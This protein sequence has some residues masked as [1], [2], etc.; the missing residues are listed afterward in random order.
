QIANAIKQ[1]VVNK[2]AIYGDRYESSD[3]IFQNLMNNL[4]NPKALM[5]YAKKAVG[6]GK[7]DSYF[8]GTQPSTWKSLRM[9][10][11]AESNIWMRDN[12]N[13]IWTATATGFEADQ[14][15][16]MKLADSIHMDMQ[17]QRDRAFSGLESINAGIRD[18]LMSAQAKM[19]ELVANQPP[20]GH[21]I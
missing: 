15:Q 1:Y 6:T 17:T 5:E 16:I 2:N 9:F 14:N 3:V 18:D 13:S 19:Q 7:Y 4:K 11:S 20:Q 8:W 12:P 21:E 10:D